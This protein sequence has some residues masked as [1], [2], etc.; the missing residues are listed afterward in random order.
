MSAKLSLDQTIIK[1]SSH[2]K[3]DNNVELQMLQSML[4][5]FTK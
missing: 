1:G 5:D 3:K 2:L 4:N